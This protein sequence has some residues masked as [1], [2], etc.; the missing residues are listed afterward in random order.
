M[1]NFSFLKQKISE[2][3]AHGEAPPGTRA[4]QA[5][6]TWLAEEF[7][8]LGL[9]AEVQRFT[10]VSW[11]EKEVELLV[12]AKHVQAIAMPNSPSGYIEGELV[13]A[14]VGSRLNLS[15]VQG[16]IALTGMIP[17]DPDFIAS[18][19]TMLVEAGALGVVFYDFAADV[20]RRIV[21]NY[22]PSHL[23]GP[24][25]PAPIPAVTIKRESALSFLDDRVHYAQLSVKTEY[26]KD[27]ESSNV[28]VV[29][30]E[31]SVLLTAHYDHWL[32]GAAD[33]AV[34]VALLLLLADE[35]AYQRDIG[36]MAF[37]AEEYGAPGYSAWYWSWGSRKYVE[38]AEKQGELNDIVAVVNLDLPVRKPLIISA[39]GPEYRDAVKELLGP[40]KVYELDSAYFDS[41]SFS[42][43]GVPALTIHSM[44]NY[45]DYYHSD[46]DTIDHIEWDAVKL[47]KEYASKIVK[48][49][50]NE[51]L[52]FFKYESLRIELL[53]LLKRAS[54]FSEPPQQLFEALNMLE[55]NEELYRKL[56]RRLIKVVSGHVSKPKLLTSVLVPQLLLIEDLEAVKR[57]L[58]GS[59]T[60]E[61]LATVERRWLAYEGHELPALNMAP[62]MGFLAR[63]DSR[64]RTAY[65]DEVL[66]SARYWLDKIYIELG[67]EIQAALFQ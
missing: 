23:E 32:S 41:F 52:G 53:E 22:W 18:Q 20:L 31:P 7:E 21:I 37:G 8:N 56:R 60:V 12:D 27:A 59:A 33:D 14:G 3:T 26:V 55:P 42:R 5:L 19:Y 51:K 28:I 25:V 58:E 2:I 66:R 54:A 1:F 49:V 45:I 62:L 11:L 39:S 24:N 40:G 34:G 29:N 48:S 67:S 46:K 30:G 63:I 4:E 43:I 50:A 15:K 13:H 35:M 65:L 57:V 17:E 64:A 6:S 47:A 61:A 10:C 44:W 9:S 36:F 38:F 16:K